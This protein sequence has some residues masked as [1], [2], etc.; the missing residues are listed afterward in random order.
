MF[1]TF[2]IFP[3]YSIKTFQKIKTYSFFF[4]QE[5]KLC[6]YIKSE[7]TDFPLKSD[8]KEAKE[9]FSKFH[10]LGKSKES[11]FNWGKLSQQVRHEEIEAEESV[12]AQPGTIS[13]VY[14]V[15]GNCGGSCVRTGVFTM[16]MTVSDDLKNCSPQDGFQLILQCDATENV[17]SP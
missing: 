2:L 5:Q 15:V 12:I 9:W 4:L 16:V 17:V 14:Q 6:N 10:A 8:S 11:D 13:E 7:G 1:S 3:K